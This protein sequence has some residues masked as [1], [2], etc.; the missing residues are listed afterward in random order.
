[1]SRFEKHGAM[2]FIT[3]E[4]MLVVSQN[5]VFCLSG[6]IGHA[7]CLF[8]QKQSAAW[9]RGAQVTCQYML[10]KRISSCICSLIGLSSYLHVLRSLIIGR[11]SCDPR[12]PHGP[13][14][15]PS[16]RHA[17]SMIPL[18]PLRFQILGLL[19]SVFFDRGV[20]EY[21]RAMQVYG[22]NEVSC[23]CSFF[24]FMWATTAPD[25]LR[26]PRLS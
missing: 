3:G 7:C 14:P 15:P 8:S 2:H 17:K 25:I 19:G 24:R 26:E 22:S 6:G 5:I 16:Q 12:T 20:L 4:S 21:L 18:G 13:A 10:K 9:G 11:L 23:R 1:M